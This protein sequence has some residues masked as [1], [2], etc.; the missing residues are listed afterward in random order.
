MQPAQNSD[1]RVVIAEDSGL[2]R[3]VLSDI[4]NC[5]DGI[6]VVDTATDGKDAVEKSLLHQP[7]VLLLD[8]KKWERITDAMP[9]KIFWQNSKRQLS[10]LARAATV[11]SC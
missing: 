7:D 9:S 10:C 5:A 3:V 8:M 4:L 1:I 2:R 6:K 11:I